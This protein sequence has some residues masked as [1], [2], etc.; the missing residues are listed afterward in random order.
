MTKS[1]TSF[2]NEVAAELVS[3]GVE[4]PTVEQIAD[5]M[6]YRIARQWEI[7][8]KLY[9]NGLYQRSDAAREVL[10]EMAAAVYQEVRNA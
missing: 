3:R 7:F 4:N 10:A 6:E 9:P 5:A 8:S 1:E 2:M